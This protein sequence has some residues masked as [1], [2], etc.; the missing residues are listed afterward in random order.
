VKGDENLADLTTRVI[1]PTDLKE[2]DVWFKGLAW[3]KLPINK[4]PISDPGAEKTIESLEEIKA[5]DQEKLVSQTLNCSLPY[6][7][8]KILA[9]ECLSGLSKLLRVTTYI[10]RFVQNC[11]KPESQRLGVISAQEINESQLLWVKCVQEGIIK[12]GKIEQLSRD[13]KA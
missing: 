9:L 4:W 10:Q 1:L 3:L 2:K 5:S 8:E 12:D 7:C 13:L 11:R 6:A